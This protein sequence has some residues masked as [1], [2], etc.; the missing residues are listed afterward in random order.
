MTAPGA[1]A[2]AG[3]LGDPLA[4]KAPTG[5]WRDT[6]RNILRQRNAVVGLIGEHCEFAAG[7]DDNRQVGKKDG[8]MRQFLG[9]TGEF[10]GENAQKFIQNRFGKKEPV[11]FFNNSA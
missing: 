2:T 6:L 3:L 1:R 4:T 5:I 8:D 11:F 10:P 7:F 9:F